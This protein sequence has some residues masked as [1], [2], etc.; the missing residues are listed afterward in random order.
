M[1]NYELFL[2]F[3]IEVTFLR[4][5]GDRIKG[6]GKDGDSLLDVVVNNNLDFDGF[7]KYVFIYL[8]K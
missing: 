5:N 4:K 3:R 1:F 8:F 7:G 6:K 2:L